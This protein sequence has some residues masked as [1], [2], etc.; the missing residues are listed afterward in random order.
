MELGKRIKHLRELKG[1]SREEL[2]IELNL[3][4]SAISKYETGVRFPRDEIL[5]N[6]IADYFDVSIDYLLGR[7]DTKKHLI[8]ENAS[9][10]SVT[11][12]ENRTI[13]STFFRLFKE[14]EEKGISIEDMKTAIDFIEMM[15]KK[16]E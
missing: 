13:S 4:Y 2:S 11:K 9:K 16:N 8:D 5:L 12:E 1:L 7:T 10:V 3:S 6:K 14:A 15:K